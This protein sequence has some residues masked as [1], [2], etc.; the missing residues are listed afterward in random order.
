M[1]STLKRPIIFIGFPRSGTTII[2][3]T[4]FQ[5]EALAWISNYQDRVPS[6]SAI[7]LIRFFFQNRFWDVRG[8]KRQLNSVPLLNRYIFRPVEG[9]NFWDYLT[10]KNFSRSFL[11]ELK[12][13][14][15]KVEEIRSF[16]DEMVRMQGRERIVMKLTGPPRLTYLHSIFPDACFIKIKRKPLPT[17]RSLLKVNFWDEGGG[18]HKLWWKG[19]VYKNKELDFIRSLDEHKAAFLAAI[20]YY[21][22]DEVQK[23]EAELCNC[24]I[25]E[26]CYEEF[27]SEPMFVIKEILNFVDLELSEGVNKYLK[28][29]EIYNRNQREDYF[30]APGLDE[31]IL[32][33]ATDGIISTS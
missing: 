29:N 22:V 32:N 7:N 21:K 24:R 13:V 30:I 26:V 23:K 10:G 28:N 14:P 6:S 1:D 3:E 2:S 12:E 18:E 16:F 19:N 11:Y 27:I 9:Y 15:E 5:H 20:Q 25:Y 8:K 17:L 33:I 31:K 4:I